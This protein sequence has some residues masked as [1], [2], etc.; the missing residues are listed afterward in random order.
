[1]CLTCA[2]RLRIL[3]QDIKCPICK[4]ELPYVLITS[5]SESK[6]TEYPDLSVGDSAYGLIFESDDARQQY[7]DLTSLKCWIKGCKS[8]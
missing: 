5:N 8:G 1:M 3:F 7:E 2:C 4:T 6:L